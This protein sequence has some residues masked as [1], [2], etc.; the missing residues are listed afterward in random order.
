MNT[1]KN[2]AITATDL[3]SIEAALRDERKQQEQ[4]AGALERGNRHVQIVEN[5]APTDRKHCDHKECSPH[6]D[7]GRAVTFLRFQQ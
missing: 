3:T 6:S 5:R 2:Q 4:A 7:V 1:T